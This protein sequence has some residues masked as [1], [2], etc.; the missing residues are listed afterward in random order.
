MD[1]ACSCGCGVLSALLVVIAIFGLRRVVLRSGSV[2]PTKNL[3]R[4]RKWTVRIPGLLRPSLDG[5]PVLWRE[6]HRHRPSRWVRAVW[7]LYGLG[8]L[9]FSIYAFLLCVGSTVRGWEE[10]FGILIN[11][12]QVGIGLLLVSVTSVTSLQD[13][14]VRGSLDV[15]L[16]TP[17]TTVGIFWGKW[18]AASGS[19]FAYALADVCSVGSARA[20]ELDARGTQPEWTG[21]PLLFADALVI[22]CYGSG[23]VSI[24]LALAVWIKGPA[25]HGDQRRDLY[26][27]DGRYHFRRDLF[28]RI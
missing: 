3:P 23:V 14:R 24:G 15:I 18:W 25:E 11:A 16:T 2:A 5:N 19:L 1:F 13:E 8:A 17:L 4:A 12:F 10:R 9:G 7:W 28:D 20:P 22:C 6:W 21:R 27:H 26:R